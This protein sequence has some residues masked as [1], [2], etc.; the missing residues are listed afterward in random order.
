[1]SRGVADH[2]TVATERRSPFI[3]APALGRGAH[4]GPR[5]GARFSSR[6]RDVNGQIPGMKLWRSWGQATQHL[7]VA[8]VVLLG[9]GSASGDNAR[10]T[11]R[12]IADLA[13]EL[14]WIAPGTF[15]MG[16][17]P[18]E[19]GRDR[20]E[21]PQM[22]VTLT[23]GFWLGKTEVTQAQYEAVVGTNPSHFKNVGAHAPVER[24]SWLEA[25]DYCRKLTERERAAGRL[26]EGYVYRLPT[27]AQW[28]YACRAGTTTPYPERLDAIAWYEA[29]SG[30][31]THGVA[32]KLPNAW[33][34][35]DMAGNVV[36]WCQD[37][38]G[39][40][41]GLAVTDPTGPKSGH[42]RMARGGSWRVAARVCRSACRSGGS[43]G[44]Q[45]YTIG[46]RVALVG[47]GGTS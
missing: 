36:E 2:G 20:A 34:L 11:S 13:L 6:S 14:V 28:E 23:K 45:D 12:A 10:R 18:N 16:S 32:T 46:F 43:P 3:C 42:F 35:H 31:T 30:E 15:S 8:G 33:G 22:T 1:M 21:G 24:V 25:V 19:E 29:N 47:G 9:A 27:E 26:P 39:D 17:P 5:T 44:R 37:W 41:A 7:F 40:Y 38:Y 4:D